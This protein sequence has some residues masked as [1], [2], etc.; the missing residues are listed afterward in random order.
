VTFHRLSDATSK[1]MLELEYDPQSFVEF[2]RAGRSGAIQEIHQKAQSRDRGMAQSGLKL[3]QQTLS[4]TN[5][6]NA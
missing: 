6:P 5:G 3:S 4:M 2:A 1:V